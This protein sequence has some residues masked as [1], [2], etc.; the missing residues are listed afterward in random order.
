[1]LNQLGTEQFALVKSF[2]GKPSRLSPRLRLISKEKMLRW[3]EI[4]P[5]VLQIEATALG[6]QS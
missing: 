1:M 2:G 6:I 5:S 4:R 3:T